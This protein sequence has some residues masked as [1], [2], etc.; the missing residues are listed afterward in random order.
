MRLSLQAA[1]A[2]LVCGGVTAFAGVGPASAVAITDLPGYAKAAYA[3]YQAVFGHETTIDD[4]ISQLRDDIDQA[5]TQINAEID[6]V[7]ADLVRSCARTAVIDFADLDGMSDAQAYAT[8]ATNCVTDGWALIDDSSDPASVDE[9]GFALNVVGPLAL[10]ARTRAY[11][12]DS[13]GAV[14]LRDTVIQANQR[15]LVRL[16]PYCQ[17]IRGEVVSGRQEIELLCTAYNGDT[18]T[19]VAFVG[20]GAPLPDFDYSAEI[21]Q[22]M[23][24]TSYPVSVASLDGL[25]DDPVVTAPVDP[26]TIW[27]DPVSV[28]LSAAR[29]AAPYRWA[30]T[31]LPPGLAAGSQGVISGAPTVVGTYTVRATV[32]DSQNQ[33]GTAAFT[34]TV[35]SRLALV[36]GPLGDRTTPVGTQVSLSPAATGGQPP[37]TWSVTGLPAGLSADAAGRITGRTVLGAYTNIVTITVT[38]AGGQRASRSLTWTVP[39]VVPNVVSYGKTAAQQTITGA[40]LVAGDGGTTANCVDPGSVARQ[41]PAGG[42]QVRPGSSV[43]LTITTCSGGGE[44]K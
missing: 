43:L 44:P 40:G 17:A 7:Q 41:S 12:A 19:G 9:L 42:T 2:A 14:L 33:T 3:A 18:G 5:R 30:V 31:G 35:R 25:L 38:D 27:S 23:R 11:G 16:R 6:R 32:T 34:W 26:S 29:G 21:T 28:T 1:C 22:A 24:N 39:V 4:A 13:A 10:A 15:N 36:T 8:A 37:Y 20:A